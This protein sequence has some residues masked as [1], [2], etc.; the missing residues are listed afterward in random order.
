[1]SAPLTSAVQNP[2]DP[3][4]TYDGHKGVGYQVQIAE[5]ATEVASLEAKRNTA[6]HLPTLDFFAT[7]GQTGQ[8]ATVDSLAGRGGDDGGAAA[9][10]WSRSLGGG[11]RSGSPYWHMD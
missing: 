3:D 9:D 5:A 8:N 4:A 7:H 11:A 1:M 2:S 6:A 10:R